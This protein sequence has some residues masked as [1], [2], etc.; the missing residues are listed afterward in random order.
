MLSVHYIVAI[1]VVVADVIAL[2]QL[3]NNN[4]TDS[5]TVAMCD[6]S[7]IE[8]AQ[9]GASLYSELLLLD[10]SQNPFV[11]NGEAY[12]LLVFEA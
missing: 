11:L 5:G 3:N 6:C 9:Q 7:A 4:I 2:E 1:I 10:P 8:L 12:I